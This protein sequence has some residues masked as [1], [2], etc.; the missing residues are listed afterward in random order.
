MQ[1]G[2]LRAS[3]LAEH[4][5][6]FG[7]EPTVLTTTYPGQ[8]RSD[9]LVATSD[10]GPDSAQKE[11]LAAQR[12]PSTDGQRPHARY[13]AGASIRAWLKSVIYFPDN[14]VGWLP[15]AAPKARALMRASAFSAVLSTAPPFTGHFVARCAVAGSRIP[16]I[17]DY[18][19]LWSA[20]SG[21]LCTDRARFVS[22]SNSASNGG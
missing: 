8:E 5:P 9:T 3:Y 17:A 1:A 6:E 15:T 2:S 21:L 14:H 22:A 12:A 7:W 16:W 11:A 4:L 18:R 20:R 19:D 10:W 13:R